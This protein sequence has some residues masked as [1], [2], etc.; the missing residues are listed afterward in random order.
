MPS[1]DPLLASARPAQRPAGAG[2]D[3]PLGRPPAWR[4][5]LAYGAAGLL[6]LGGGIWL[7]TAAGDHDYR[8]PIGKLSLAEVT[9]GPF[10]DFIAVR[11]T[12]VPF[13]TQYLTA[14]QG[15]AVKQVLVEDGAQ[16]KAGQPLIVLTNATLQ[17]QVA[18]RE[19]DTAGQ[20]NAL[21]NTRIQLE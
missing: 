8:V 10:E 19:A 6:V 7:R 17:L 18:S 4:R 14:D 15:G 2:M 16:V 11:S 3:T 5:Y 9:R 13:T 21:E 20:I 12:A 1:A